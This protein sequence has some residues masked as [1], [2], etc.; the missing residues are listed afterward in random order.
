MPHTPR[1]HKELADLHQHRT[2]IS[3]RSPH[4]Q[5]SQQH[6]KHLVLLCMDMPRKFP[7]DPCHLDVLII[8]LAHYPRRPQLHNSFTRELQRYGL[9]LRH[10]TVSQR[11]IYLV[12]E[13]G[14]DCNLVA[15]LCTAT[16]QHGRSCLS[17]HASQ[18]AVCL[19]SVAAVRLKSALRHSASLLIRALGS[20]SNL[21]AVAAIPEYTRR[22]HD[23]LQVSP[24]A[25]RRCKLQG[26]VNTLR[27]VQFSSSQRMVQPHFYSPKTRE[28]PRFFVLRSN[29]LRNTFQQG[30]QQLSSAVLH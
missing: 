5:L 16:V 11:D 23:R 13:T 9:V 28:T 25:A 17:L 12:A 8:N 10:E 14:A 20:G 3:L 22:A 6:K 19:R 1:H 26:S 29:P 30:P 21:F 4:A 7:V 27:P 24:W 2:A 18:K 15:T